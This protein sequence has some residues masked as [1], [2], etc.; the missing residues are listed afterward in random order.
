MAINLDFHRTGFI[1]WR[2]M[3]TYFALL[4][5]SIPTE[6]QLKTLRESCK[7]ANGL[8]SYESFM[9]A[10]FWFDKS[11]ASVQRPNSH[12]F[13]RV[14]MIKDLLFKT[15]CKIVPDQADP[16]VELSSF[17]DILQAPLLQHPR[18]HFKDYG[19]YLFAPVRQI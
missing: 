13:D 14:S 12:L 1:H 16:M 19:E 3:F 5:S 10:S 15:H 18:E 11:E 9:K 8:A 17:F 2:V 4:K 7:A 6:A